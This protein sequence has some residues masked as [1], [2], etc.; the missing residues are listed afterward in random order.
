MPDSSAMTPE[1]IALFRHTVL[2]NKSSSDC[3]NCHANVSPSRDT[4]CAHCGTKFSFSAL[5]YYNP[6]ET[7]EE[8]AEQ[9]EK[10]FDNLIFVGVFGGG[11]H[12]LRLAIPRYESLQ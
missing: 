6:E 9:M 11:F 1:A 3:G 2:V 10:L 5:G 7:S 4:S 12:E 8:R